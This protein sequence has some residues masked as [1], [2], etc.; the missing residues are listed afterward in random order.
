MYKVI[1]RLYYNIII[2]PTKAIKSAE[3]LALQL[4]FEP[5]FRAFRVTRVIRRKKPFDYES[6]DEV[7]VP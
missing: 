7:S 1:T 6:T 5:T 2:R 4:N 3:K